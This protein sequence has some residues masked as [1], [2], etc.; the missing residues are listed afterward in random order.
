V[1]TCCWTP[2]KA[3]QQ[4]VRL[5]LG[6][7]LQLVSQVCVIC[8]RRK[9]TADDVA[10]NQRSAVGALRAVRWVLPEWTTQRGRHKDAA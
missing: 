5:P 8:K 10:R 6:V 1:S 9:L 3:D 4:T 2:T 7:R